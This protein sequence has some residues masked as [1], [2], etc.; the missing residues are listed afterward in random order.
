MPFFIA[1]TMFMLP[2]IDK[3]A[4]ARCRYACARRSLTHY[5]YFSLC[6]GAPLRRCLPDYTADI[7]ADYIHFSSRYSY[8]VTRYGCVLRHACFTLF[9][10]RR[11]IT[12]NT[13]IEYQQFRIHYRMVTEWTYIRHTFLRYCRL[14]TFSL[15]RV[16]MPRWRAQRALPQKGHKIFTLRYHTPL[17]DGRLRRALMPLMARGSEYYD[18]LASCLLMPLRRLA[19]ALCYAIATMPLLMLDDIPL[20]RLLRRAPLFVTLSFCYGRALSRA[21]RFS[22]FADADTICFDVF[23]M[24]RRRGELRVTRR[25]AQ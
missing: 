8:Y 5:A 16:R 15:E 4:A 24:A 14:L 10:P 22:H 21:A 23:D 19:A 17:F 6:F 2:L 3:G 25:A 7:Y 18:Y 9:T 20:M 13:N 1:D 11:R 12:E